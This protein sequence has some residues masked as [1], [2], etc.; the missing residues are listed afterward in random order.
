MSYLCLH[1][2]FASG[3]SLLHTSSQILKIAHLAQTFA[4]PNQ[5]T[6]VDR[7]DNTQI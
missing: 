5:F 1:I 2:R 4:I 7:M 3:D 6:T